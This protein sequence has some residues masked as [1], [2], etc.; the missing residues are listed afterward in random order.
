MKKRL[1]ALLLILTMTLNLFSMSALAVEGNESESSSE[2]EKEEITSPRMIQ[3]H[4][5]LVM[6]GNTYSASDCAIIRNGLLNS[7]YDYTMVAAYGWDTSTG[8]V[9]DDRVEESELLKCGWYDVAYYSGHGGWTTINSVRYPQINYIPSNTSADYGNSD[10]INVASAFGVDDSDWRTACTISSDDRLRVLILSSCSQ[11][12][13]SIVKYYARIM[14]ASGIRAIAGYHDTAPGTGTDDAIA[15]KFLEKAGEGESVWSSWK[16]ANNYGYNW[17]VLV[18][19]ENYNQYYRLPGFP[20]N[21]YTDPSSTAAIY[22]YADF[23]GTDHMEASPAS[24]EEDLQSQI[25]SLPLT[26]TTVNSAATTYTLDRSRETICSNVSIPD[27]YEEASEYLTDTYGVDLSSKIEVEHYVS[28][29]EIDEELGAVAGTETILERTY[30]FYDTY[31][32]IKIA[33]SFIGASVDCE[34]INNVNDKRKTV[35]FVGESMVEAT[36]NGG[37][38]INM[39]SESEAIQIAQNTD[40]CCEEFKFY[41]I[42]LAYAPVEDGVHVLCYE[43]VSSCGFYYVNVQ[44]GEVVNWI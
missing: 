1:L 17:A 14:R 34:G 9:L 39:I 36:A 10:P 40:H 20:G 7:G 18:Y 16:Q 30:T 38:A 43:V 28:R 13:S 15:Q 4:I 24:V 25:N 8:E 42:S 41:G 3:G 2:I 33:D 29:E 22:R 32:G 12:D 37:R 35:T 26:L 23:L 21:T 6:Q 31:N 44:T 5:A 11:L 19:E 27:A